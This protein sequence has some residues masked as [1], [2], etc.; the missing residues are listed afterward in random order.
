MQRVDFCIGLHKC[1]NMDDNSILKI[2]YDGTPYVEGKPPKPTSV[3]LNLVGQPSENTFTQEDV[4]RV[5]AERT[6]KQG[7]HAWT[8]LHQYRGCD[9]QWLELWVY[10]IPNKCECK[11]GYQKILEELPPDFSSPE[12][13]FAW[14]VALHNAVNAKLGK[15]QITIDEALSIWRS[16]DARES[17]NS[18]TIVS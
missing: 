16:N 13:F 6:E 10:F 18:G 17:Q 11:T 15:P 4:Q 9:P 8:L 1:T 12:A 3:R 7:Q 5:R 2:N 14:G